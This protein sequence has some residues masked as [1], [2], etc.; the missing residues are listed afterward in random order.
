MRF[1]SDLFDTAGFPKRWNCGQWSDVH[2]WTHI[3]SDSLIGGAYLAIPA[4]LA[5]F[6]LRRRDVPFGALFWAFALFILSCGVGHLIEATI[7]WHPW[8]RLSGMV[9][10]VTAVVSWTTVFALIAVLPRALALPRLASLS[11]RLMAEVAE[12]TRIEHLYRG[13][14]E[15]SPAYHAT[16]DLATGRMTLCNKSLAEDLGLQR[17]QLIGR[18]L[19]EFVT[20]E[21]AAALKQAVLDLSM[22]QEVANIELTLKSRFDSVMVVLFSGRRLAEDSPPGP[23]LA[24]CV[25]R[26]VTERKQAERALRDSEQRFQSVLENTPSAIL[27]V[28]ENG[29]ISLVNRRAIETFGYTREELLG[30]PI[31]LL[32]PQ[33]FHEQM[34]VHRARYLSDPQPRSV[35][36]RDV[37]AVRKDGV[38]FPVEIGLNPLVVN[39]RRKVV[40]AVQDLTERQVFTDRLEKTASELRQINQDLEQIAYA[41]SHDLQEPLRAVA[42]YCQLLKLDYSDGLDAEAR[43]YLDK[44]VAGT[45][46]MHSLI[47]GLLAFSRVQR[48]GNEFARVD[49]AGV[50]EEVLENLEVA[51]SESRATIDIEPLPVVAGDRV[52]IVQLFQNLIG[53]AIKYRGADDPVIRI[54]ASRAG[55]DW[56]FEVADNG[57]GIAPEFREKIFL[58]FQRLHSRDDYDGTGLGLAICKQIVERHQGTIWVEG[59]E[60]RGSRFLLT[61]PDASQ[62]ARWRTAAAQLPLV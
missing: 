15:S 56:R 48:A 55:N 46:R 61:L 60:G 35:A 59:E 14:Y 43:D 9:K 28:D 3:V 16:L 19:E 31:E 36:R 29:R 12:R 52:Q 20:D 30:Q 1:V 23:A 54:T 57:I 42:G 62:L 41:A 4:V 26:N 45:K 37:L 39:G 58:I 32:I 34:A 10:A 21:S 18:R 7:F 25:L 22:G 50:I 51:I 24:A 44:A 27:L 49:T 17:E 8:Y 11:E 5:W 13:L 33:R 40:A 6:M 38:E 53:N 47:H 2:G